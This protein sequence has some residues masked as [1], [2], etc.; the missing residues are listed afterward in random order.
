LCLI[1]R[2]FI[3]RR[4]INI[5]RVHICCRTTAGFKYLMLA[6]LQFWLEIPF[7]LNLSQ[8]SSH[9]PVFAHGSLHLHG[10]ITIC[11]K[12]LF[13]KY[14]MSQKHSKFYSTHLWGRSHG[15]LSRF[16]FFLYFFC[17]VVP[18]PTWACEVCEWPPLER[19]TVKLI[20]AAFIQATKRG[21]AESSASLSLY[22]ERKEK[23]RCMTSEKNLFSLQYDISL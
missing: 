3:K 18:V 19:G 4:H 8:C 15:F 1:I 20:D 14:A 16:L 2:C 21:W 12:I 7:R 22:L 10:C 6:R 23:K 5:P 11:F 9:R 13:I 17:T